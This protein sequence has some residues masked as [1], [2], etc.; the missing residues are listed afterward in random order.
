MKRKG[1]SVILKEKNQEKIKYKYC[2]YRNHKNLRA[3]KSYKWFASA[4]K[5]WFCSFHFQVEAVVSSV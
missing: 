2:T 5:K 1:N 4:I 3:S